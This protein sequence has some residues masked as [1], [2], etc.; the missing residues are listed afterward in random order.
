MKKLIYTNRP[1]VITIKN[2]SDKAKKAVLFGAEKFLLDKNF[3]SDD[4]IEINGVSVSYL[5]VIQSDDLSK[6]TIVRMRISS[7][8]LSQMRQDLK[9]NI[10]KYDGESITRIE[11]IKLKPDQFQETL[12]DFD[13]KFRPTKDSY[14]EFTVLANTEVRFA[15]FP[16]RDKYQSWGKQG[17]VKIEW[18]NRVLWK[19]KGL[20]SRSYKSK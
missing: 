12:V 1:V 13:C 17:I 6:K 9:F 7:Q 5:Q 16:E 10:E 4:G 14:I 15:F 20:F 19:I 18:V 11:F 3:G 2:T 8:N